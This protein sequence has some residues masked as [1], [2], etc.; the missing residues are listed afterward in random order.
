MNLAVA[1]ENNS[2]KGTHNKTVHHDMMSS[3][4]SL[5]VNDQVENV[6]LV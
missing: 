3:S 1:V 2:L 4:R 5:H 6:V